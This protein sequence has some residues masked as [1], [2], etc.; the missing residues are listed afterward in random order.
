MRGLLIKSFQV[1]IIEAALKRP[2]VTSLGRKTHTCNV[3]FSLKLQNGASGYGEASASL[4]LA[5]L[6]PETLAATLKALG[7]QALGKDARNAR[8]L[9]EAAWK[10]HSGQS[11][12]VSAFE[13]ALL[14]CLMK[15]SRT[16][17]S[18]WLGGKLRAVQSDITLSAWDDPAMT[19][20][21]AQEASQEG[22]RQFKIKVGGDFSADMARIRAAVRAARR[23]PGVI[24]DGNQGMSVRGALRLVEAC[25]KENIAVDLLEQPL[26]KTDFKGMAALTRRCPIP[27]AA[28][29]MVMSP[30]EALRVADRR[31]AGVINIK[32]AKSGILKSLE[33]AAVARAAGLDLMIGC[34]A[35]T[36]RGLSPSVHL[37]LGTGFFR[38][39]DLDSD[40]LLAPGA[41][42]EDWKRRGPALSG[43]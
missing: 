14:G 36:A 37:A 42:P 5:H 12:A 2:F 10:R 11:P 17:L 4:A 7:R 31:A 30:E 32:A 20:Q 1:D 16:T 27:V 43:R 35:E 38:F 41:K 18:S 40:H 23:K 29:E 19:A 13:C 39:V 24:L 8:R 6:R 33:I 22:F 26:P 25:L 3:A 34:M 15:S 28:D 21:A 9:I